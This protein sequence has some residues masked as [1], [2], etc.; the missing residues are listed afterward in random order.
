M[1]LVVACSAI[2]CTNERLLLR[3]NVS[4]SYLILE[5]YCRKYR[6]LSFCSNVSSFL[7]KWYLKIW[8]EQTGI[9]SFVDLL[10][11]SDF[12][13]RKV[14]RLMH[15]LYNES[16][17]GP[18]SEDQGTSLQIWSKKKNWLRN[19]SKGSKCSYLNNYFSKE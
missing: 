17:E 8:H 5:K 1:W 2:V 11:L 4:C 9:Y 10:I 13:G 7:S 16:R 19:W 3:Q 15:R 18:R 14:S 6:S 12:L